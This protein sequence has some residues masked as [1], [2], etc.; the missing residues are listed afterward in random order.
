MNK[1]IL[2]TP[3]IGYKP[4]KNATTAPKDA[5]WWWNGKSIFDEQFHAVLVKQ[6]VENGQ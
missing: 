3:P 2:D 4:L 5:Q 1:Q 6:E